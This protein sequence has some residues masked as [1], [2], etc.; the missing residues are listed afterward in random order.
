[1]DF[2]PGKC[3]FIYLSTSRSP[4]NTQYVLPGQV[5]ETV[6]SARYHGIDISNDLSWKTY[7]N[8]I[9]SNAKIIPRVFEKKHQD[10]PSAALSEAYKALVRPQ[11]EYESC[12]WDPYIAI[13]ILSRSKLSSGEL[14][15]V[16]SVI[17]LLHP[18]SPPSLNILDGG[19]SNK[20]DIP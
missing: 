5:L 16:S 8:R 1:M 19:P 3:Q 4:I 6:S 2:N 15:D 13:A 9:T 20:G 14:R 18:A 11:L 12:V 7:I 10:K 17:I